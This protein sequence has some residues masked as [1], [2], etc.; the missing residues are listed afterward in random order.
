MTPVVAEPRSPD[1]VRD[2]ASYR[3]PSGFVY[4]REGRLLR[5]V[6]ESYAPHWDALTGSGFLGELI[7]LGLLIAHQVADLSAAAEPGAHAVIEPEPIAFLSYPYEWTFGELRDAALLTLEVQ[8]RALH[9]GFT[10]KDA[11]AYNVQFRRGRPILIDTLSFETA[12]PGEPWIAYRQFCQHFLAPLALMAYR[13]VRC[14]LLLRD[15]IDGLPLDLTSRLLPGRTRLRFGL[16]SHIHLHAR[17]ERSFAGRPTTTSADER[18]VRARR[19]PQMGELRLSALVDGLRRSTEGLRWE[20]T[21]TEWADY[22]ENTSY[23]EAAAAHK[24]RT[25]EGMLAS[26]SGRRVWD[27]GANTGRFSRIAAAAGR[28]VIAF[29]IDPGAAE[30]HYRAIR[31][32]AEE[33][34]LPLV[35]DIASPSPG[36]GWAGVERPSLLD[37]AD[38]DVV[39]ALALVHHLAISRNVP[40][41]AISALFARLAP[42]AIVEFVPKADPMVQFLL[43]S[44]EDVFADYTLDGFRSAFAR[45]FETMAEVPLEGS[46]RVLFHFRR[47][48]G[49]GRRPEDATAV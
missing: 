37:R 48:S 2:S 17:A 24:D 13:D 42:E 8:R 29:D 5:Q 47:R 1:T 7:E 35:A 23:A 41:R 3:D 39:L 43:S 40:L 6:N 26:T 32:D 45:D 38:A 33:R 46:T 12:K 44:R 19:G 10:L 31:T 25:V 15:F 30:R 16:L 9:A 34:I 4:R 27:L 18:P 20:P 28:E 11:S 21:G 14:S 22:A 36:L 49:D